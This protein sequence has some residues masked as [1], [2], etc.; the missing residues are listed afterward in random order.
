MT[1]KF[2]PDKGVYDAIAQDVR[3]AVHR[4]QKRVLIGSY[5]DN[6]GNPWS[7]YISLEK[8]DERTKK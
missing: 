5:L 1:N 7:V 8:A 4:P 3:H 6:E 2:S